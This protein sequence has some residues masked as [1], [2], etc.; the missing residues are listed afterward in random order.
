[1]RVMRAAPA[2]AAASP[3]FTLEAVVALAAPLFLNLEREVG[4]PRAIVSDGGAF[5]LDDSLNH[6]YMVWCCA[7]T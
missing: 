7:D 4:E 6:A 2:A 5:V 3:L 1:M